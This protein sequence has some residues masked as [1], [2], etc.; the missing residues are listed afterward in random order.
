MDNFQK[1]NYCIYVFRMNF[2][3]FS[4]TFRGGG[5]LY[6]AVRIYTVQRRMIGLSV[7]DRSREFE[8]KRP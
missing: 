1:V 2:V 6:G 8:T 3:F 7:T 4:F 5:L